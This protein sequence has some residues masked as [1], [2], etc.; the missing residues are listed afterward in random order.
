MHRIV[1][2]SLTSRTP[3]EKRLATVQPSGCPLTECEIL[4]ILIDP[5]RPVH[6]SWLDKYYVLYVDFSISQ[7]S[8]QK[9]A[10][11][12]SFFPHRFFI[13]QLSSHTGN[14]DSVVA[15]FISR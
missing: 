13:E 3:F 9:A 5:D 8:K 14:I 2:S 11:Q 4:I 1:Y 12:T 6:G 15:Q 7:T 10:Q